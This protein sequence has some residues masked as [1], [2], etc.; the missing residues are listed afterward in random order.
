VEPPAL[1]E[2][3]QQELAAQALLLAVLFT[4]AR[5]TAVLAA[6]LAPQKRQAELEKTE[7]PCRLAAAAAQE[8]ARRALTEPVEEVQALDLLELDKELASLQLP[9]RQA[10]QAQDFST[11]DWADRAAA[12]TPP[13]AQ[14]TKAAMAVFTARAAAADLDRLMRLVAT[15]AAAQ[16]LKELPSSQPTSN[17]DRAIRHPRSTRR[18]PR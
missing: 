14:P 3:Q 2:P 1:E 10:P 12:P 7:C 6:V 13:Q 11:T 9:M 15:T 8:K 16:A 5:K 18:T 17:H 4:A